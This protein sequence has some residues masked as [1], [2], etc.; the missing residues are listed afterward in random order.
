MLKTTNTAVAITSKADALGTFLGGRK[1]TTVRA[2]RADMEDFAAFLGMTPREAAETLFASG[3]GNANLTV[4][5]YRTHLQTR[6]LQPTTVNRRLATLRSL[7]RFARMTGMIE[8]KVE[9]PSLKTTAYRDTSGPGSS[10][11]R[12]MLA[13][14]QKKTT[15]KAVRDRAI[16]RLL[17]DLGL[18][19]GELV[20]LDMADVVLDAGTVMVLGKGKLQ[21]Q[22][23]SLPTPTSAALQAWVDVRGSDPGPLF[24]NCDRAGQG[25][26]RLTGTAVYKIVQALGTKAGVKTSP[27]GLRHLAVT[28]A[29][30]AAQKAGLDVTE[31]LDFSRHADLKT[32]QIYIDRD[33]NTQGKI[34]AMIA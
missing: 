6:G 10:A 26:G 25:R 7:T 13:E 24:S 12:N 22:R 16:L 14:T 2:Y 28:E 20:A 4:L 27:H 11:Y 5:N 3:P 1:P 29:A 19:R 23:L 33:S 32:L 34:A 21:R 31:V 8:W 30:R 17:H 9:V 15:K 18:R